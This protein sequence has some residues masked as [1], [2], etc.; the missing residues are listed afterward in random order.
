[1]ET[2]VTVN[3]ALSFLFDTTSNCIARQTGW[4]VV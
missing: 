3:V 1:M 2:E 4:K